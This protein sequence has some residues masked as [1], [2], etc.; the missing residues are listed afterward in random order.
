M[1]FRLTSK[2][3]ICTSR[4]DHVSL[5]AIGSSA[6]AL[7]QLRACHWK[8]RACVFRLVVLMLVL[9]PKLMLVPVLVPMAV[10]MPVLVLVL[11]LVPMPVLVLVL[12][13]M[14][15]PLPLLVLVPVPLP[16]L[17]LVPLLPP[18]P[19][20]P[21]QRTLSSRRGLCLA[22]TRMTLRAPAMSSW[23]ITRG[24]RQK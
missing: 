23:R 3:L 21:L 2:C 5:S 22:T 6:C 24:A 4:G 9:V 13:L 20:K 19:P 18:T 8:M 16:V 7:V 1:P 14:P 10:L 17:V 11:V 12:V 15:M